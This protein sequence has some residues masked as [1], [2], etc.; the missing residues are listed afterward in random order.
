M[1][2]DGGVAASASNA[3]NP[4]Q[5]TFE[6]NSTIITLT[7]PIG[8]ILDTKFVDTAENAGAGDGIPDLFNTGTD[9][10]SQ[11][12][13][14]GGI[15]NS[16]YGIEETQG[17]TNTTLFAV[18]D[19]IKDGSIPFKYATVEVAGTLTDGVDHVAKLNVYVD[20]NQ[21]NGQNYVVNDLVTGD[22]SGVRGTVL[23]WDPTTGLLEVGNVVPYNTGNINIGIAGYFYEFSARETVIDFIVQNPGTNYTAPPTVTVENIGDIQATANVN[24]TAA[25][26]QVA[27]LTITNGGYGIAQNIDESFV[28]HPTV[29]FTNNASDSTGSGAVVQAVLGG[30]RIAGN[31]G[32]SYRIKRI[33]YQ[34]QLQSKE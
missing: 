27:S 14:D 7:D 23:G 9:Y 29:T 19:Q 26:D 16:L 13:L 32:A 12:S 8:S 17:G 5:I 1:Q 30:E 6:A 22:I 31:T 33:E 15:Y 21:G 20:L 4:H 10:E 11:I 18:A 28:T 34:A 3:F 25:G 2:F 24:M